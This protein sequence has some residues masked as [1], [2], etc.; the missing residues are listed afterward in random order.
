[1]SAT[2]RPALDPPTFNPGNPTKK[3]PDNPSEFSCLQ[4]TNEILVAKKHSNSHGINSIRTLTKTTEGVPQIRTKIRPRFATR[5]LIPAQHS[6]LTLRLHPFP[7][8]AD[9]HLEIGRA[10]CRER[11]CTIESPELSSERIA[12][13]ARSP[14]AEAHSLKGCATDQANTLI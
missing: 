11:V 10:S 14:L 8:S 2:T 3:L 5:P 13:I 6:L 4:T 9:R 1:M 7:T 12:R